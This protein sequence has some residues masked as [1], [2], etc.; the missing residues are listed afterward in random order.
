M[1]AKEFRLL[2]QDVAFYFSGKADVSEAQWRSDEWMYPLDW[3][4]QLDRSKLYFEPFDS[5]GIPLRDFGGTLQRQYL[6]SRIAAFAIAN[7]NRWRGRKNQANRAQFLHTANWLLQFRSGRFE[8]DFAVA[9]MRAPWISCISQG[10][11]AS[12]LCR[13]YLETYDSKF[14]DS[15]QLAIDPFQMSVEQGGLQSKLPDGGVFLEE[16]PGT[17][18][19]HVLN[20]CLYAAVG[21][22]DV[23]RLVPNGSIAT[24]TLLNN[25][26]ESI[27]AN[28]RNWDV[29]GWSV[30]DYPT[31]NSQYRNLNT[32]TYQ[33]LQSIL[34]KYLGTVTGDTRLT[35]AG[36]KWERSSRSR[37]S[38]LQALF[39]KLSYRWHASW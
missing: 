22:H 13:A 35:I 38:R 33:V 12:V 7:W 21:I 39:K 24:T 6:I 16:Y 26:V 2:V 14:L 27:G 32:M 19:A 15:A 8:H 30:Y 20:G 4:Y 5:D 29:S 31:A 9:G 23:I 1:P 3:S 10:E 17:E 37:R 25:I 18:Y 28:I 36:D 34:L 11:V